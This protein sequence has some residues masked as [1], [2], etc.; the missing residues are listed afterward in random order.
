MRL[1]FVPEARKKKKAW[2]GLRF[3]SGLNLKK[4]IAGFF[5]MS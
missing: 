4:D 3:F 2:A 5:K 1:I